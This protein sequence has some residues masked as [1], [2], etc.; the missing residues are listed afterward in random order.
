MVVSEIYAQ[1]YRS[2]TMAKIQ[3]KHDMSEI[4]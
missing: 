1:N 4:L 3:M 2:G